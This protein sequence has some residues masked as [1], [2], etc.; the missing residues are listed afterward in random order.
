MEEGKV[1]PEVEWFMEMLRHQFHL[2]PTQTDIETEG[3]EL[4]LDEVGE[5]FVPKEVVDDLPDTLL[6]EVMHFND[7]EFNHWIGAIAYFPD[8]LEWC[9]KIITMNDKVQYRSVMRVKGGYD[10]Q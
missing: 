6:Y 2:H 4:G 10:V 8:H 5:E 1:T 3:Y 7:N 9:L